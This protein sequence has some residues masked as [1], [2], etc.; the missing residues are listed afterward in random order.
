MEINTRPFAHGELQMVW[1]SWSPYILLAQVALGM[2]TPSLVKLGAI[3][4][5]NTVF[6]LIV[7]HWAWARHEVVAK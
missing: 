1:A 3:V 7:A 4:A 5:K 2:Y 6:I